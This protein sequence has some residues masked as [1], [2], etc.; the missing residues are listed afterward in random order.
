MLPMV[1]AVGESV[2]RLIE[3]HDDLFTGLGKHKDCKIHLHIDE[4]VKPVA[5]CQSRYHFTLERT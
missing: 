5:E 1:N 3:E 2:D 4:A